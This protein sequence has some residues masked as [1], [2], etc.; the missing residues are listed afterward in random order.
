MRYFNHILSK[1]PP[2]I[3]LKHNDPEKLELW[4]K[5]NTKLKEQM[6]K[7]EK[8]DSFT[9]NMT[10][11]DKEILGIKDH[12]KRDEVAELLKQKSGQGLRMED[13]LKARGEIK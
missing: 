7:H 13:L 2:E 10:A 12:G 11:E 9:P 6:D 1:S 4:Y 3:I 5:G 8:G